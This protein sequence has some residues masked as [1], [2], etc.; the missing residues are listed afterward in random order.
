MNSIAIEEL[1]LAHEGFVVRN[2]PTFGLPSG[3]TVSGYKSH[4]TLG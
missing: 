4:S 2:M 1:Q 3:Q